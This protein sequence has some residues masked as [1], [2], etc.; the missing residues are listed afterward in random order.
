MLE[1]NRLLGGT[2][3]LNE[4]L[5]RALEELFV[6]YP[7]AECGFILTLDGND[8][9]VPQATR[10]RENSAQTF[11]LSRTVLDQVIREGKGLIISD[12]QADNSVPISDSFPGT[13]IRTALCAPIIGHSKKPIGI[14]QLD[15]R[16]QKVCFASEDLSLLAAVAV[17]IA[18]IVEKQDQEKERALLVAAAEV[19][20]A[21][22]PRHRPRTQGYTFWEFYQPALEV[23]GDYYDYIDVSE[24]DNGK[25]DRWAVAVA[26]VSG[27]GMPAALMMANLCAEVR[28]L[29]R[30]G[31]TTSQ[32]AGR[33]NHYIY[34]AD[35]RYVTFLLIFVD[36]RTHRL[37]A[38]NCGHLCPLIR[39]A[40]GAVERLGDS[41]AGLPLGVIRE[42]IYQE[43]ETTLQPGEVVVLFTDGVTE[44]MDRKDALLGMGTVANILST[45][46]GSPAEVGDAIVHA[47]RSHA[48]KRPQSDDI[49]L[50]CFRRE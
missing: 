40:D 16:Q 33:L 6:I 50:I 34:D 46:R 2:S 5:G 12:S 38:V 43:T 45:T 31:A 18:V 14:I 29:V 22:L 27:K 1:I 24:N 36:T 15:C 23:G 47:V 13:G 20:A 39:R 17:P 9:L 7:Q 28:H 42:T 21:L 48:G 44:A 25:P 10:N 49:A 8:R 30:S 41:E 11:S 3:E 37:N 35:I 26:D 4:V 19:Q 32:V